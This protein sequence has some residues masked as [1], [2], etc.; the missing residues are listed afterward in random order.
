[1]AN[2]ATN[3]LSCRSI[4]SSPSRLKTVATASSSI[5]S[6]ATF[7]KLSAA[8]LI[9]ASAGLGAYY[10][11]TSGVHHG[12][13]LACL[14]V[15]MALGLEGAKPVSIAAAFDAW[16][17][18]RVVQGAALAVLG[19]VAVSYSLTAEL[20]LIATSR[21]DVVAERSA[22]SDSTTKA[23]DRYDRA[24]AELASLTPARPKAELDAKVAALLQTKGADGCR[25]IN[26]KVT[27]ELCPKIADLRIEAGRAERRDQ[28]ETTM[29]EA[30][31][32]TGG[33]VTIKAGDP[34]AT[35]LAAYLSLVGFQVDAK[36]LTELL[37]LVGVLALEVGSALSLVMVRAVSPVTPNH[38]AEV[39]NLPM[40]QA[41][42]EDAVVPVVHTENSGDPADAE[43]T[44]EDVKRR[45]LTQLRKSG[46]KVSGS[47]RGLAKLIGADK[48]TMRRA[49]NGLVLAGVVALQATRSGTMLRL[50]A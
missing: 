28:L 34:A 43:T 11:W 9:T 37:I 31:G 18:L 30:E 26:G 47:Q 23:N 20:S 10:A 48:T 17:S 46:G 12:P 15:L 42:A 22:Q 16:R 40:V 25:V 13:V 49:I 36:L 24:K 32:Q 45:V 7:A 38:V 39:V 14:L 41:P 3:P 27:A 35:A 2:S 6:T 8:S 5:L 21:G 4:F 19:I 50:V 29:R 1:M 33:G 44:R